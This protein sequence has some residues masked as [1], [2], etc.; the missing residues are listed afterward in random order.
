[1]LRLRSTTLAVM[2]GIL[3]AVA[4]A[5]SATVSGTITDPDGGVVKDAQ[6]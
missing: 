1:M 5:Q 3:N 6:I 4:L 2:P